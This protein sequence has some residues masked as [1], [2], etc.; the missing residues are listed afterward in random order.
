[1][2][3][4]TDVANGATATLERGA[5]GTLP[6]RERPVEPPAARPEPDTWPEDVDDVLAPERRQVLKDQ[7]LVEL[8]RDTAW[9]DVLSKRERKAQRR[10]AETLRAA[11]RK[12]QQLQQSTDVEQRTGAFKADARQ[13]KI[14]HEERVWQARAQAKR[15]RLMDPTSRLATIYRTQV[16]VSWVLMALAAIGIGWCTVTVGASLGGG[17]GYTIEPLFSVPLL[18]IMALH[19]LAAQNRTEFLA[20]TS[21]VKVRLLEVTLFAVTIGLQ[22]S[23]VIPKLDEPAANAAVLIITHLFPPAL[24]VLSVTLQP[25]VSSFLSGLLTS[26]YI[27]A[28][29]DTKRLDADEV[30][31]LQRVK[32]INTLWNAG[33]LRSANPN[34]PHDRTAGPSV[35][36][37][38]DA[39]GIKKELCQAG[40]DGWHQMYGTC[41]N[42]AVNAKTHYVTNAVPQGG[43]N[44]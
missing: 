36:A 40:V 9:L 31:L 32:M 18:V 35:K 41:E 2:A 27:E 39:L 21:K 10:Q 37:V 24:I 16:A 11:E 7:G 15:E 26:V 25:V 4:S 17:L 22:V 29:K 1:M 6:P 28:G 42:S 30:N 34:D 3:T 12:L 13:M 19:A 20:G 38:Q 8:Q 44:A 43:S 23:A 33:Q 5:L 14:E